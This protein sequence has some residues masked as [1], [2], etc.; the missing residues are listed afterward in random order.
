MTVPQPKT[1]KGECKMRKWIAL[2]AGA[3]LAATAGVANAADDHA[4]ELVGDLE[5]L[6]RL[7]HRLVDGP[8]V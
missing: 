1:E 3:A 2:A 4:P 6:H 5:G 8:A 7:P